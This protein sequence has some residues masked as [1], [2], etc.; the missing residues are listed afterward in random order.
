ML[1]F[2]LMYD[3]A[4]SAVKYFMK[5]EVYQEQFKELEKQYKMKQKLLF[6]IYHDK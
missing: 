3:V 1:L 5:Q 6:V 4:S 2:A